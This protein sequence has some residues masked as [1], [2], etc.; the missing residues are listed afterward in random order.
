MSRRTAASESHRQIVAFMDVGTNSMRL[1][2]VRIEADG[3]YATLTEQKESVRLGEGEFADHVVKPAALDRATI[4][5]ARFA[6]MAATFGVERIVAVAT[7]AAREASNKRILLQRLRTASGVDVRVISGREEARLIYLGV[8]SGVRFDDGQALFV[9]IGGG[10]TELIV[11]D[12]SRHLYLDS[13]R[14][15]AIRLTNQFFDPGFSGAVSKR[16]YARIQQLVRTTAVRSLQRLHKK[17]FDFVV[18]S[19]GTITSLADVTARR[20]WNRPPEK[21][22]RFEHDQLRESI[23]NLA[24]MTLE[25]R[26]RIPGISGRRAAIIVAGAAIIDT[27][28]EE[29][30]G[31]LLM[32][33]DRT[34][35]DGLLI[36]YLR[37]SDAQADGKDFSYRLDSVLRLGRRCRFDESHARHVAALAEMLFDSAKV[38]GLHELGDWEQEILYYAALLH[39][40]GA[41]LS[42]NNHREHAYYFIRNAEL[43][44]F[45]ETEVGILA[46]TTL[47]HK[48]TYPRKTDSRFGSL[49]RRSR[50]IVKVLCVLLRIAESLDRSHGRVIKAAV[51]RESEDG[52]AIELELQSDGDCHLELWAM[53]VH[54]KAFLRT[55]GREMRIQ[56][57]APVETT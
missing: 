8:A 47:F 17:E 43:L 36:D 46:A 42:Y 49:D 15:G 53:E 20:L 3:S 37:R 29:L 6:E 39:D 28:L 19:S 24:G 25:E 41:F 9:D 26:R 14:L 45:D 30:G 55:F 54:H 22:D 57:V 16:R 12:Q 50:Q 5:A 13:L 31:P 32:V 7:S 51:F 34:L 56:M 4:V 44:G 52:Q 27:M 23:A 18:G 35:R 33:S 40:I 21:Q 11:G 10:S 48:K 1:L 2:I 38:A